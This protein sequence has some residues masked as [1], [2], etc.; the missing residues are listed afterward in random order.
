MFDDLRVKNA[1][2]DTIY[3]VISSIHEVVERVAEAFRTLERNYDLSLAEILDILE[4]HG[5]PAK[6][7]LYQNQQ[8]FD[9]DIYGRILAGT[10]AP[11]EV[12]IWLKK[13]DEWRDEACQLAAEFDL[14]YKRD[15]LPACC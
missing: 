7:I 12:E 6:E 15:P 11:E 1:G 4:Q 14:I 8:K 10:A 3:S 9:S 5:Y 2:E 13:V